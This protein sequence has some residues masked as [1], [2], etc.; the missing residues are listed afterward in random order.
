MTLG[1][2]QPYFMPYLGYFSMIKH[3]DLFILFDTP[4][5]IRHG[6]IERNKVLKTNGDTLYIKVPL[7]KSSRDTPM[8]EIEIRN[9]ENWKRKIFAQLVPYKKEARYYKEV[10]AILEDA[11]TTKTNSIVELN[12]ITLQKICNYLNIDTPIKIWSKMAVKI[13][14][15]NA[16][17]EWALNICKA[18][19]ANS[20]YNLPGGKSFFDANKYIDAGLNLQFLELEQIPYKQFNGDFVPNLSII[21]VLMFNDIKTIGVMLDKFKIT[22][23]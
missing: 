22:N 3:V 17:D 21:D 1:I 19:G 20:Y 8:N 2:M 12:F 5:F 10:I 16:P 9:T 18:M 14:P 15:V 13:E 23:D 4:Q 7:V 11:F 6:W